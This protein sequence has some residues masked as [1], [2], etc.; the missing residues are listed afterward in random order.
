MLDNE[1]DTESSTPSDNADGLP[2]GDIQPNPPRRRR[3]ATRPAGPPRTAPEPAESQPAL[4]EPPASRSGSPVSPEEPPAT[5]V[6]AK[7]APRK[8]AAKSTAGTEDSPKAPRKRTTKKAAASA[9]AM[10]AT[11]EPVSAAAA[12]GEPEP[13]QPAPVHESAELDGLRRP[14]D[15]E[16]LQPSMLD[17]FAVPELDIPTAVAAVEQSS[18]AEAGSGLGDEPPVDERAGWPGCGAG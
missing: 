12:P 9:A 16:P 2:A 14:V 7:R 1:P 15:A 13:E 8:A 18:S 5:K 17:P 11:P 6:A 4:T 3:A 10:P